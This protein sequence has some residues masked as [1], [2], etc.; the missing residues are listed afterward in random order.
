[1]REYELRL[2]N[3]SKNQGT[4][5]DLAVYLLSSSSPENGRKGSLIYLSLP[6]YSSLEKK[7]KRQEIDA[8][9]A[10]GSLSFICILVVTPKPIDKRKGHQENTFYKR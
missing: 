10:G 6:S 9:D 5:R 8:R 2:Q 1:V 3:R 7:T 4:A